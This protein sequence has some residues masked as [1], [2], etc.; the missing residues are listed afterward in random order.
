MIQY[1]M[2]QCTKPRCARRGDGCICPNSWLIFRSREAA[3]R[4]RRKE[5]PLT[6]KQH[7]ELYRAVEE[8]GEFAP[9][10]GQPANPCGT[11]VDKLCKWYAQKDMGWPF[12]GTD[13]QALYRLQ[14]ARAGKRLLRGRMGAGFGE[15]TG[16]PVPADDLASYA[17]AMRLP[18]DIKLHRFLGEGVAGKVFSAKG[19]CGKLLAVKAQFLE[20]EQDLV[21][22]KQ[23]IFW[24]QRFHEEQCALGI[25][26]AWVAPWADE[27]AGVIVMEP[28]DGILEDVLK[29]KRGVSAHDR[30]LYLNHMARQIKRMYEHL[31]GVGLVHGDMHFENLAV[32]YGKGAIEGGKYQ[33]AKLVPD[34]IFLDTGRS[35]QKSPNIRFQGSAEFPAALKQRILEDADRF[36][37]WRAAILFSPE[38]NEPLRSVGFPGSFIMNHITGTDKPRPRTI[39]RNELDGHPWNDELLRIQAYIHSNLYPPPNVTVREEQ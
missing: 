14:H 17:Q 7:S 9:V 19:P 22:F 32:R 12:V 4:R 29:P 11:N 26:S 31:Q 10:P 8:R 37:V 24:Q 20:T 34:I 39:R 27:T 13:M 25:T 35:F 21:D 6:Q 38:I 33:F 5:P 28:I 30:R 15:S 36:W 16:K 1:K 2:P 23:E 18:T 3:L